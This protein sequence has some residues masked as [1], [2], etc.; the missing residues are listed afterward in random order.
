MVQKAGRRIERF[1]PNLHVPKKSKLI[2]PKPANWKYFRK[3]QLAEQGLLSILRSVDGAGKLQCFLFG[4]EL[5][6]FETSLTP[7]RCRERLIDRVRFSSFYL[8]LTGQVQMTIPTRVLLCYI[9]F[10]LWMKIHFIIPFSLNNKPTWASSELLRCPSL[11]RSKCLNNSSIRKRFWAILS[12]ARL[13]GGL[14]LRACRSSR[15]LLSL[16]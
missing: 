1:L 12:L 4:D 7:G 2:L 8:L 10:T 16:L 13:L 14:C 3:C 15:M 6:M 5:Q 9:Q 11:F